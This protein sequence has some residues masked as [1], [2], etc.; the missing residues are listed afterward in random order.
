MLIS[1]QL[2]KICF[3]YMYL[4]HLYTTTLQVIHLQF[5]G[6]TLSVPQ[7]EKN[8]EFLWVVDDSEIFKLSEVLNNFWTTS[9]NYLHCNI[10]LFMFHNVLLRE[11]KFMKTSLK[12]FLDTRKFFKDL[13]NWYWFYW[14]IVFTL[15]MLKSN[16]NIDIEKLLFLCKQFN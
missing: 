3:Q 10:S 12:A 4:F 11:E 7:N 9:S 8:T 13:E 2:D 1:P 6:Q 16:Y 5:W 14:R 15:H